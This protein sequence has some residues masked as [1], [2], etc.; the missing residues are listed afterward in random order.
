MDNLPALRKQLVYLGEIP[1]IIDIALFAVVPA[2]AQINQLLYLS[3]SFSSIAQ[4]A[5]NV[6][7]GRNHHCPAPQG[8]TVMTS[9]QMERESRLQCG[10]FPPRLYKNPA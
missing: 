1:I 4:K 10:P 8:K 2:V 9:L 6:S 5:K 3:R 7:K